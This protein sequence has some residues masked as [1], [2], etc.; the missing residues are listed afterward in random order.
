MK[1]SEIVTQAAALVRKRQ[2]VTYRALKLE[3][4]LA[5]EAFEALKEELLFA[6][7]EIADTDGRG[8]VWRAL[9][10]A[11]NETVVVADQR[12]KLPSQSSIPEASGATGEY[13]QLSVMFVDLVG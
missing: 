13:R 9:E 8:L 12:A 2:R 11:A 7:A 10:S 3:F 5:D 4:D 1:F 6:H